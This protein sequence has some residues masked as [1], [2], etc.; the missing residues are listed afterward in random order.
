MLYLDPISTYALRDTASPARQR[1]LRQ[2]TL[3]AY[4]QL[5]LYQLLQEM[6]RTVPKSGLFGNSQ[7]Q[8]LFE[9]MLDDVLATEMAQS[10]QL[11]IAKQ[12]EEQLHARERQ[13]QRDP[14]T[15]YPGGMPLYPEAQ[16]IPRI[17]H[18]GIPLDPNQNNGLYPPSPAPGQ[19]TPD[20]GR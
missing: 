8:Q 5:F 12:M 19:E 14:T 1:A 20:F 10:G 15:Q 4:E 11:G 6:R 13:Q 16:G 2:D 9:D 3:Q 7:Q 18:Q 17:R